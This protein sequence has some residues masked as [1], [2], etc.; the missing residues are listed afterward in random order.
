M[1]ANVVSRFFTLIHIGLHIHALLIL[2]Q[3]P[4]I[5]GTDISTPPFLPPQLLILLY[6]IC[7]GL[8]SMDVNWTHVATPVATTFLAWICL[9]SIAD[10]KKGIEE[11]ETLKYEAKGA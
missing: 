7:A 3:Q 8:F 10:G 9:Q 6:P 5:Y 2:R 4:T 1:T 11:L